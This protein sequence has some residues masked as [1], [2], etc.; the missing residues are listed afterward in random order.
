MVPMGDG[1]MR[2]RDDSW[3]DEQQQVVLEAVRKWQHDL[4]AVGREIDDRRQSQLHK[5]GRCCP[6]GTVVEALSG[7]FPRMMLA[8]GIQ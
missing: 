5:L 8:V 3:S 1:K 2:L 7:P 6:R 4:L